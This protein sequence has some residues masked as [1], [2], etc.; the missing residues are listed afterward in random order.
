MRYAGKITS[1]IDNRRFG[2][3]TPVGGGK[4]VFVHINSFVCNKRR[5]VQNHIVHLIAWNTHLQVRYLIIHE[6]ID[7]LYNKDAINHF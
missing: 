1:W 6:I 5:P 7:Y 3:I 4:Q 2:F